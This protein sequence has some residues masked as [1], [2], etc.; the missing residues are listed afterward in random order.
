MRKSTIILSL[1]FIATFIA[2]RIDSNRVEKLEES[3]EWLSYWD[4]V[5]TANADLSSK[6]ANKSWYIVNDSTISSEPDGKGE[7]I[8]LP[9]KIKS[10]RIGF[11][12]LRIHNNMQVN[13]K[14]MQDGY[15]SYQMT[16]HLCYI[17]ENET[18]L[19]AA[20]QLRIS[21]RQ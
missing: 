6:I 19:I 8:A 13:F 10:K 9:E 18:E 2:W 20:E 1:L 4:S 21:S 3:N 7:V 11:D 12:I 14:P 5:H 15:R 16:D 17:L